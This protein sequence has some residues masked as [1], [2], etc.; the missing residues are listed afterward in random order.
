MAIQNAFSGSALA[1]SLQANINMVGGIR[2]DDTTGRYDGLPVETGSFG[3]DY[4]VRNS[5]S[6][7]FGNDAHTIIQAMNHLKATQTANASAGSQYDV[8]LADGSGGFEK[9]DQFTYR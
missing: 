1:A 5:L 2:Y 6:A 9:D 7:S 4:D 3:G 8:Q